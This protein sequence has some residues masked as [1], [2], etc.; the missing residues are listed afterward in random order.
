MLSNVCQSLCFDAAGTFETIVQTL[1]LLLHYSLC[2]LTL[3]GI[4]FFRSATAS[5]LTQYFINKKINNMKFC[6]KNFRFLITVK[7]WSESLS[8]PFL[9]T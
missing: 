9:L 8:S 7:F 1:S 5:F 6:L 2:S 3:A 4:I